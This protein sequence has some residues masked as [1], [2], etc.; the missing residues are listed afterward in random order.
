[1][2]KIKVLE[3]KVELVSVSKLI[4]E[5]ELMSIIF[6]LQ[7]KHKD[8]VI[9]TGQTSSDFMLNKLTIMCEITKPK[10]Y[11]EYVEK[12]KKGFSKLTKKGN[13]HR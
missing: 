2:R 5:D 4:P 10:G 6:R 1:M 8:G 13:K 11:F 7:K 3:R 12:F 9:K